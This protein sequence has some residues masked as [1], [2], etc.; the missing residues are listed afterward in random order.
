MWLRIVLE[1]H[2]LPGSNVKIRFNA[3][4][5]GFAF[6]QRECTT[7]RREFLWKNFYLARIKLVL[8]ANAIKILL[9]SR[10]LAGILEKSFFL[11]GIPAST[12]F[13]AGFLP[14]YPAGIF[15]GKDSAGNT[16][17]LGGIPV[18]AVNLGGIPARS[19]YLFYKGTA[20]IFTGLPAES[21]WSDYQKFILEVP[22]CTRGPYQRYDCIEVALNRST[23]QR[24]IPEPLYGYLL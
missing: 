14:R 24:H 8:A 19:R 12:D 13:S 7:S 9:P 1:Q 5:P 22:V 16:G 11:D 6:Q 3:P 20:S 15:P 21:I 23:Y 17:H 4:L 18:S 2:L 10:I